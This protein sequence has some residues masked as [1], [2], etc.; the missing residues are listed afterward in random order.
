QQPSYPN[1]QQQAQRYPPP[2]QPQAPYGQQQPEYGQQ[3]PYPPDG[4]VVPGQR[5]PQQGPGYAHPGGNGGYYPPP[6]PRP[7]Y[8]QQPY[9]RGG[10]AIASGPI[11]VPAGTQLMLRTNGALDEKHAQD[12][13]P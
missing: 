13:Q 2:Q 12:G 5:V 1:D 4:P 11:T 8:G 9:G 6:P 7:G 3:P 10:Y